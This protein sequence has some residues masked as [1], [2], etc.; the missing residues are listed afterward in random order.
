M[1][2]DAST[3]GKEPAATPPWRT[4]IRAISGGIVGLVA[5]GAAVLTIVAWSGMARD[6][7]APNDK[8]Y[9]TLRQLNAGMSV[10]A[11]DNALG[12]PSVIRAWT[13]NSETMTTRDYMHE[14][15]IVTT[16]ARP[17]GLTVQYT[18]LSCNAGFQPTFDTPLFSTVQLRAGA[19]A[20]ADSSS[21]PPEWLV[22]MTRAGTESTPRQFV[23][24]MSDSA[25][26][27]ARYRAYIYGVA[28]TCTKLV[29]PEGSLLPDY[30]GPVEG[31]PGEVAAFREA[32]APNFYS[33]TAETR[34]YLGG[35]HILGVTPGRED[36][37]ARYL[38]EDTTRYVRAHPELQR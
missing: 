4:R 2:R 15:F 19:L 12:P 14:K 18:V 21:K 7:I 31:A 9:A 25:D 30:S 36:L 3:E 20:S 11:F 13:E 29:T 33:E 27:E 23:E 38:T 6:A 37:P 22:V 8:D 10:D 34:N 24:V 1:G 28:G 32:T 26:A 5:L 35:N 17:D 16:I